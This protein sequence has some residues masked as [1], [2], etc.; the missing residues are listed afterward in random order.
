MIDGKKFEPVKAYKDGKV[1]NVLTMRE[2]RRRYH[3][4]GI[5]FS[6]LYPGCVA[7]TLRLL[8]ES[9]SLFQLPTVPEVYHWGYVS[10]GVS[11]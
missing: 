5:T 9:L 3:E 1:C 4:T 10:P 11:W 7:E 2:L 6:S 8:Q